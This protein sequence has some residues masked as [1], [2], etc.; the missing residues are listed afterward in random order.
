MLYGDPLPWLV[1]AKYLR[2][3]T[4][5]LLDGYS[6]DVGEKR[7]QFIG[8]NCDL[9]QEFDY[10]HPGVKIEITRIYN[11]SFLELSCGT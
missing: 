8:R 6:A 9:N 1:K 2:N 4:T 10:A 7:A 11:S 3:K 5:G